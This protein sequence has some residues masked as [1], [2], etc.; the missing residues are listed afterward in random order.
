MEI[1]SVN[2]LYVQFSSHKKNHIIY[3]TH[4]TNRQE[5]RIVYEIN[6]TISLNI[7]LKNCSVYI[8]LY[9]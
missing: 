5:M 1:P 6:V 9:I 3:L 4:E 8:Y 2:E 7:T